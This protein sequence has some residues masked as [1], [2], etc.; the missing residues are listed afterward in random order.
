[1][2]IKETLKGGF[3]LLHIL[4][5]GVKVMKVFQDQQSIHC[6]IVYTLG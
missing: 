1:M 3:Q 2:K 5:Q 4:Q 6:L